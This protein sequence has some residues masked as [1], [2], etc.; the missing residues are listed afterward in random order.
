MLCFIV[1]KVKDILDIIKD[2]S[3]LL[4]TEEVYEKNYSFKSLETIRF[5]H[6]P[7]FC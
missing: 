2:K 4:F 3:Y 5:K 6:K 1:A 7:T